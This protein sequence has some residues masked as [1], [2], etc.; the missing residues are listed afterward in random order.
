MKKMMFLLFV[1]SSLAMYFGCSGKMAEEKKMDTIYENVFDEITWEEILSEAEGQTVNWYLWGGSPNINSMI[2]NEFAT[3]AA[4]YG[5]KIN[6]VGINNITEAIN[7]II[8]EKDAGK[9]TG[10]SVDLLWVNGSNFRTMVEAN[11]T[12]KD[13]SENI[14]NSQY[15]DWTDP[16]IAYDMGYPVNGQEAPWSSAQLQIVYDSARVKESEL[17]RSYEDIM[18]YAKANPGRVT[19]LAPPEFMGT[20]FIKQ[21]IYELTGGPEQYNREGITKD[22][23]EKMSEEMW[24]WLEE[25]NPYLWSG[26]E[27]YAKTA[28]NSYELVNNGEVDFSFSMNGT[29]ISSA[30]EVGQLP[31]TAKVYCTNTSI[32]D[33]SYVGISFNGANKAGAMVL[34]NILLSP[35]MQAAKI[36][37][38]QGTILDFSTL[39]ADHQAAFDAEY[40]KLP[41]GTYVEPAEMARTKSPE[42]GSYLNILIEEIWVERIGSK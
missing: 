27:T 22:E 42:V 6:R 19:Y 5:V 33:T 2:D 30:I 3:E 32:A 37:I 40:A 24:Q 10:G 38:G 39:S 1:L 34:A 15:V 13:W 35:E 17:P 18:A 23:L 11:I 25:I 20:R 4:K 31:E 8:S 12:L 14:P 7:T 9:T 36:G 41:K 26:G 16:S 28:A 29:G 21:G